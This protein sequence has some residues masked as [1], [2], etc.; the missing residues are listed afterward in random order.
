MNFF[1]QAYGNDTNNIGNI[2]YENSL[3]TKICS[4]NLTLHWILVFYRRRAPPPL[5]IH[6]KMHKNEIYTY[7]WQELFAKKSYTFQMVS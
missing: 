5:L 2:V 3:A 4:Q 1:F 6:T 7:L